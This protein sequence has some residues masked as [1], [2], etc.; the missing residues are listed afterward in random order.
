MTRE[1]TRRAGAA[2]RL[3]MQMGHFSPTG[4]IKTTKLLRII[5][6]NNHFQK[7]H[8]N[9]FISVKGVVILNISNEKVIFTTLFMSKIQINYYLIAYYK[10]AQPGF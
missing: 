9:E 5:I 3:F 2:A 6:K 7:K 8:E 10:K 1:R 4:F